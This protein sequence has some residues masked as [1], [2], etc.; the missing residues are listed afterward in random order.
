MRK[1]QANNF[2]IL[3]KIVLYLFSIS[4]M[5]AEC[6]RVFSETKRRIRNGRKRL[7]ASTIEAIQCQ[8]DWLDN[9]SQTRQSTI[10]ESK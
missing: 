2:P 4:A 1:S 6:E 3:S 5:S 9:E 7:L 8:N 10:L